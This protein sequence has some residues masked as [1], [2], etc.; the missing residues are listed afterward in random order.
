MYSRTS[1]ATVAAR[2]RPAIV[3]AE[4]FD[5]PSGITVL[6]DPPAP[7]P[8]APPAPP[9]PPA[10]TAEDLAAAREEAYAE[11]HRTGLAQAAADRAEITRQMLTLIAERL[12]GAQ[13]EAGRVAAESA[14]AVARL[15]MGTLMTMLPALCARHGAAEVAA[16]VRAVLPALT[17]EPRVTIRLSPHLVQD[18]ERELAA[19][20]PE[21][22]GRVTLT[23]S[24]AVPPGDVRITWHDGAAIR[25]SA[26][27]LQAASAALAPLGLLAPSPSV[28][29]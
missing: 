4:D 13:A 6:D 9:P 26:S 12:D 19:L 5:A 25:D 1:H 15:L 28:P 16:V 29:A 24:E 18:I 22:Q 17:R 10:I 14:E 23:A 11:G 20:D 2:P 27:L 7:P 8:P 21:L 3:F